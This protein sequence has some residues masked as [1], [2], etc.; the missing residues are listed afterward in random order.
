MINR[1]RMV[2]EF[3]QLAGIDSISKKERQMADTLTQKLD[4]MGYEVLEDKAGEKIGGN[5]GNL[6]CTVKGTRNVPAVM[7]AAHMDTVEPG[8]GKK[9]R[10]DGGFIKSDGTTVLGG[11]D[12]SGIVCIFEALRVLKENGHEH[13]DI[14]IV[15]TVAEEGGLY[16]SK[17][18]DYSLIYARYGI[19]LDSNGPIGTVAVKAPSQNKISIIANGKAS[20]A[21]IEPEKGISAIQVAAKAISGMKLGKIDYETTAN[22]GIINGGRATNIICERVEMKAEA[23]SRD[24]AKLDQQTYHMRECFEQAAAEFGGIVD[25]KAELEYPSFNISQDAPIIGILKKA[26]AA[27]NIELQL[28]ETGGGS[29]T[30]IFNSR[31]IE[32]VDISTGMDKV[33]SV[34]ECILIEDMAKAAEFVVAIVLAL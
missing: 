19:V 28:K 5:S 25:F 29:D 7:L 23:R 13:G 10:I 30:N 9:P 26:A 27:A 3:L 24:K 8:I 2:E 22:I 31:G 18:L 32:A 20:H 15:L 16:G 11:D 12:V 1:E 17:H 6:I 4:V 21:G 34:E 33:H 14:Q